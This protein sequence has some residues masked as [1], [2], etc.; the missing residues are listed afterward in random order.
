MNCPNCKSKSP[1]I[2]TR[3]V[4]NKV[5]RVHWCKH[6]QLDFVTEENYIKGEKARLLLREGRINSKK[7]E[8]M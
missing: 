4:R 2:E 5:I 8:K 1:I 6:C 3:N 7:K